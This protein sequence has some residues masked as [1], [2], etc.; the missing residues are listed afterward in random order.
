MKTLPRFRYPLLAG[1]ALS[2]V[3]VVTAQAA[4]ATNA[5]APAKSQPAATNSVIEIPKS[6]FTIPTTVADGRDPFFPNSSRLA[7]KAVTGKAPAA[8]TVT[9]VLQGI[10]GTE[11]K[12][13]ALISGR[14]MVVG[15]EADIAVDK[16]R[17]RVRCLDIREDS[18]VVDV[19]GKQQELKLRPGL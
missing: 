16:S 11:A 19:D 10:S 7:A 5:P 4:T 12:R 8:P 6:Q 9:L 13:F 3:L 17:V 15:E 2:S 1:L 14:T 18:V